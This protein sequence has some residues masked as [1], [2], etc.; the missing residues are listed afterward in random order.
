[1]LDFIRVNYVDDKKATTTISAKHQREKARGNEKK[2]PW[3]GWS[4]DSVKKL[5]Q[6]AAEIFGTGVAERIFEMGIIGASALAFAT[7]KLK[8]AA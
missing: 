7:R 4:P 5:R 3:W 2:A 8:R 1:M 6:R